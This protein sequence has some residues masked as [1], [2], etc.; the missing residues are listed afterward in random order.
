MG[1]VLAPMDCGTVL[2]PWTALTPTSCWSVILRS[3]PASSF[4]VTLIIVTS[5]VTVGVVIS[6]PRT[7]VQRPPVPTT[8]AWPST[9]T[10]TTLTC[11]KTGWLASVYGWNNSTFLPHWAST[12]KPILYQSSLSL[13]DCHQSLSSPYWGAIGERR[14]VPKFP[15]LWDL[16]RCFE[17][18]W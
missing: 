10:V 9:A 6:V 17:R 1:R 18:A 8:K 5:S 14:S 12:E 4:L 3:T 2:E 15:K 7:S 11:R 16:L 13:G